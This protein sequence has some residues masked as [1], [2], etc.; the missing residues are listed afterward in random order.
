ML[1]GMRTRHPAARGRPRAYVSDCS[2]SESSMISS[3]VT[4]SPSCSVGRPRPAAVLLRHQAT[5]REA[6]KA[7]ELKATSLS[8]SGRFLIG[9]SR[10]PP[11][12]K[13]FSVLSPHSDKKL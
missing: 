6:V 12:L 13:G 9:P 3:A 8:R 4:M 2:V 1:K 11:R 5:F 7:L 10:S